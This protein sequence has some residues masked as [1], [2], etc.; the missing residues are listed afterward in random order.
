MCT[1]LLRELNILILISVARL[2]LAPNKLNPPSTA[3]F[4]EA[5]PTLID[6]W[7]LIRYLVKLLEITGL[8]LLYWLTLA[9]Q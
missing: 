2:L 9:S 5:S 6:I 8:F 7:S 4:H 3:T 1:S